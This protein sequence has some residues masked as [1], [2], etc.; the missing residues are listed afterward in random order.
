MIGSL[1]R[2]GLPD[3]GL[4]TAQRRSQGSKTAAGRQR[5][6]RMAQTLTA[7]TT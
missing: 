7:S 2:A 6:A 3:A 1:H 5:H 4:G